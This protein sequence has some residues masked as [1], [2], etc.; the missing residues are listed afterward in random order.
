MA[1]SDAAVPRDTLET[2][3]RSFFEAA[4]GYGFH[5]LDY[6]R[7]VN[8][9]L[10]MSMRN[11]AAVPELRAAPPISVA[12]TR[13]SL[14]LAAGEIAIRAYRAATDSVRRCLPLDRRI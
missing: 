9:I 4:R 14:P 8:L 2:I 3:A 6:L 1:D 10:D 7:F 13:S 12:E 11:D 5:H